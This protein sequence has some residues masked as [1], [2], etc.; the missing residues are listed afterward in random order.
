MD[1]FFVLV[2]QEGF[3]RHL[4]NAGTTS[5]CSSVGSLKF[6]R[7]SSQS[8]AGHALSSWYDRLSRSICD[9]HLCSLS[10]IA[11]SPQ[12]LIQAA[13]LHT[14]TPIRDSKHIILGGGFDQPTLSLVLRPPTS[15]QYLAASWPEHLQ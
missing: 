7:V 1:A 6:A 2:L 15:V 10:Q 12:Q 11:F 14:P 13:P 9:D 8:M 4:R 5:A 3:S